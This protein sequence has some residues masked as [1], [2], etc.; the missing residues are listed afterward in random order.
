MKVIESAD[1]VKTTLFQGLRGEIVS[2]VLMQVT[3]LNKCNKIYAKIYQDRTGTSFIEAF[4]EQA[5]IQYSF[6][7]LDLERI[8]KTGPFI[9]IAN[10][11]FGGLDALILLKEISRVRPDFRFMANM[12]LQK[13]DAIEDLFL[14][15]GARDE[16]FD[17]YSGISSIKAAKTHLRDGK[18]LGLFPAGEVSS[19]KIGKNQLADNQWQYGIL[20]LIKAAGVPVVPVFF[21]G[22][23]SLISSF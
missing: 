17:A 1:L 3:R 11:P 10:H 4:L 13:I 19:I 22:N 5:G 12:Y 15:S 20:K 8:P 7:P 21:K 9:L 16:H 6:N 14:P 23:N 2:R 18:P